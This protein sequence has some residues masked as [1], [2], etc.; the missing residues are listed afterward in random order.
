MAF[1]ALL[2]MMIGN[3]VAWKWEIAG[4]AL[5]LGGI[6]AFYLIDYA[7]TG[8]FPARLLFPMFCIPGVLFLI[9]GLSA[10]F[11]NKAGTP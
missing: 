5:A 6:A 2:V 10:R 1:V 7:A 3:L 11:M 4:G 9:A 8:R